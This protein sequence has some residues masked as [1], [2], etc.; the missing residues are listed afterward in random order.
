MIEGAKTT[1]RPREPDDAERIVGWLN[2]PEVQQFMGGRYLWSLAAEEAWLRE[3][4]PKPPEFGDQSFA[5]ETKDGRMIGTIG[6]HGPSPE[7][8]DAWLGIMIGEK[9]CWS[10]GYG[11]DAITALLRFAFEEM[12]L[13]RVELHVFANNARGI[14][15]YHK[16]GFVEEVRRRQS[17]YRNSRWLDELT[18]GVLRDEFEQIH[19]RTESVAT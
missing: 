16:C 15:C 11:T 13:H 7:N 14:A 2:D 19:V 8:R 10:Q 18:M 4:T 17:R 6:L 9:D 5:I 1:L 3:R 12:N